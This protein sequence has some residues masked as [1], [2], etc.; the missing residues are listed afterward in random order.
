MADL[1]DRAFFL[2]FTEMMEKHGAAE[3][4]TGLFFLS[5]VEMMK[6]NRYSSII[7]F[8]A[9]NCIDET[10]GLRPRLVSLFDFFYFEVFRNFR[11]W[12]VLFNDTNF[13]N[14]ENFQ[15]IF[16]RTDWL[17]QFFSVDWNKQM[18]KSLN[19]LYYKLTIKIFLQFC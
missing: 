4:Q 13:F 11:P 18:K 9:F 2:S 15:R 19:C 8:F 12:F 14:S 10:Q 7:R 17:H 6:I 1:F 5:F 16:Q 3:D